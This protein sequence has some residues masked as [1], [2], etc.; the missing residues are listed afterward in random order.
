MSNL[1]KIKF[2]VENMVGVTNTIDE[3]EEKCSI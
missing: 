2:D 1:G 3:M